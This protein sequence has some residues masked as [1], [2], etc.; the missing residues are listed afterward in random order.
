M[1]ATHLGELGWREVMLADKQQILMLHSSSYYNKN[2]V[3]LYS[4]SIL[5]KKS[6]NFK[7]ELIEKKINGKSKLQFPVLV[8]TGTFLV[9][10]YC[11]KMWSL[12]SLEHASVNQP[13]TI[14]EHKNGLVLSNT[15]VPVS[16]TW[17]ILFPNQLTICYRYVVCF[18]AYTWET[19]YYF[20][21]PWL[22]FE[23]PYYL[24]VQ[25]HLH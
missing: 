19:L 23:S 5:K 13:L 3:K 22:K 4:W 6:C 15:R 20:E 17:S 7:N 9:Y 2:H 10:Q 24:A 1:T 8:N 16:G 11:P 25:Y 14:L 12:R 18:I 21:I